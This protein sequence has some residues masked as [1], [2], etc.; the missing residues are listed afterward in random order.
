MLSLGD[1]KTAADMRAKAKS[2]LLPYKNLKKISPPAKEYSYTLAK[3]AESYIKD[4]T[5]DTASALPLLREA[6]KIDNKNRDVY[7]ISGD[8]WILVPDGSK[9]IAAYN[10]AQFADPQS[11]T[12]AM[13]IGNIYVAGRALQPAISNFEEA[14]QLNAEFAP[15][16]REL[17]QVYLLAQRYDQSK[18][19]F[20]KYLELTE[21]N[22]P[23]KNKYVNALFYAKDYEGVITNVEDIFAVD[24]SRTI[25]NR[26]AGYSSYE[27]TPPDYDKAYEYMTTLFRYFCC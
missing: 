8:I 26:L 12:A 13:K 2:F 24:K 5:V 20:K 18:E 6:I 9:A 3:I 21:G 4:G 22:I 1:E 15:A 27:K 10:Q 19:Y 25:M 11:P 17:G 16:Y 23:A 14:I 7:L